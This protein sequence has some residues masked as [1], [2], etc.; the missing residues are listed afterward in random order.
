MKYYVIEMFGGVE[1]CASEPFDTA[2]QRD[3][4]AKKV[5]ADMKKEQGDNVFW[6][7]VNEN[8]LLKIGPYMEGDL[9]P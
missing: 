7:N 6:S 8:G 3:A 5:W 4:H 9:D 2:E 1:A